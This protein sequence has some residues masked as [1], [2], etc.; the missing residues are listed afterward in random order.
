MKTTFAK[1][2]IPCLDIKNGRV[3]KGTNF[4]GLKDAGSPVELAKRYDKESADEL[5]LLDIT[6]SNENRATMDKVVSECASKVFIPFTVGGGIR[7]LE[8]MR[9]MLKSGADKISINTAAIKN[10]T[11]IREGA[12]VF[13]SQCIV[14]AI[15]ARHNGSDTWE[16]YTNGGRISTGI[17]CISWAKQ[18]AGLGAGEILLTSMDAD[19]TKN[20]YDIALTRAISE[21][22][23]IPVIA[24]GGAGKLDHF[25]EVLTVG[26]AD[27]VLAASL[28]HYGEFSIKDVKQY[29]KSKGLGVRF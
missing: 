17:D 22:V 15:D 27:A 29:L 28:F 5:I 21:A 25:Y 9:R 26:K 4:I 16:V 7:T 19:G 11:L 3:V 1:R 18:A 23:D 10:P 6:A 24:S 13:G 8:D 20:G 2:I 12:A 14:I